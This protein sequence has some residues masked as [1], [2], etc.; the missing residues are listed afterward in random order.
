MSISKFG[1]LIKSQLRIGV[2]L[3]NVWY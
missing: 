1:S 3:R 2:S